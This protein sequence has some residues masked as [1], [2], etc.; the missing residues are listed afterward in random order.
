MNAAQR[1]VALQHQVVAA[2][3]ADAE[4]SFFR[5][6]SRRTSPVRLHY[7]KLPDA[8]IHL[9]VVSDAAFKK[10]EEKGRICLA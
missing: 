5:T 4:D 1:L 10:E 7:R 3:A 6:S 8:P 2:G 9:K